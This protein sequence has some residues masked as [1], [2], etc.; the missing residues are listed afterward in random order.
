M[1]L[2]S[3]SRFVTE[4]KFP[5]FMGRQH[6]MATTHGGQVDLPDHIAV[7]N[8][9]VQA[10]CNKLGYSGI[11]HVTI[12]EKL[13]RKGATQRKPELHVDGRF[14][15]TD[16]GHSP[17]W[18]HVCNEVPLPRMAVAVASNLARCKVYNGIFDGTPSIQG[19]LSHI[20]DQVGEGV[21]VPANEWHLLSPDCVHESLPMDEDAER[22]FIRVAFE[23]QP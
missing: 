16:W 20:R 15:G 23:Q 13:V 11:I 17:G 7:Y 18:N 22:S 3:R 4:I 19:D 6:Y 21:L 1:L 8:D 9:R 12:D 14:T 10:L 5:A 2:D